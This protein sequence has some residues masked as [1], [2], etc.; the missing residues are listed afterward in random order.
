MEPTE[1]PEYVIFLSCDRCGGLLKNGE[2]CVRC[3]RPAWQEPG[4]VLLLAFTASFV[5]GFLLGVLLS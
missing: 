2:P 5:L 4:A 1:I 3:P